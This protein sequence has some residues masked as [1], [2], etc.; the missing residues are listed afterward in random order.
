MIVMNS[1][2][3]IVKSNLTR[4]KV[5]NLSVGISITIVS[6]LFSSSIGILS[7]IQQ[8]FDR[9]F[10]NLNAS[11]IL[12]CYDF[13]GDNTEAMTDWFA[14]QPEVD[15]VGKATAYYMCNGPLFFKNA[16]LDVPVQ[17]TE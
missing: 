8:P 10:N 15:R 13:R 14:R 11:H 3:L 17:I 16:K 7:S 9:V 6:L 5:Q 12:L 4:R 1:V 2:S